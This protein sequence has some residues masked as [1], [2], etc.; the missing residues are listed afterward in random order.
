MW[1]SGFSMAWTKGLSP[2]LAAASYGCRTVVMGGVTWAKTG[3]PSKPMTLTSWG[4]R[5]PASVRSSTR[6]SRQPVGR[7]RHC[8]AQR[9]SRPVL[10]LVSW[11]LLWPN[12]GTFRGPL[13]DRAVIVYAV[14][15]RASRVCARLLSTP[16]PRGEA[17]SQVSGEALPAAQKL[18]LTRRAIGRCGRRVAR[19]DPCKAARP[20]AG[21]GAQGFRPALATPGPQ[22]SPASTHGRALLREQ[23]VTVLGT[24][25]AAS[26]ESRRRG[27]ALCVLLTRAPPTA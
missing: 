2:S 3:L 22:V 15:E 27:M 18:L 26:E 19:A 21:T 12:A 16:R 5:R 4:T 6:W 11:C 10:P 20:T 13:Y 14:Q 17:G 8:G 9:G 7:H 25:S 1:V 23:A 24:R